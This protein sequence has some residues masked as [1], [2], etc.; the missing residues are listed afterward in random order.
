[1]GFRGSR[2]QIPPSRFIYFFISDALP[3][4]IPHISGNSCA[5][6]LCVS[7]DRLCPLTRR[8]GLGQSTFEYEWRS[9]CLYEN[10]SAEAHTCRPFRSPSSR[11]AQRTVEISR[12]PP[13]QNQLAA[14]P[15][16]RTSGAQS[17]DENAR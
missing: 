14:S 8:D 6:Q 4:I 5:M 7:A 3:H 9:P 17:S 10:L 1:M 2:V 13:S 15:R 11:G 12:R 16:R